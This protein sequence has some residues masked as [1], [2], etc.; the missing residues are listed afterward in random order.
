MESVPQ[1]NARMII[2]CIITYASWTAWSTAVN[3]MLIA[4]TQRLV[5]RM[6]HVSIKGVSQQNVSLITIYINKPANQMMKHIVESIRQI[7]ET[8]LVIKQAYVYTVNVG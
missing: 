6:V 5:S 4:A 8:S 3:I 7:A 1:Q 2:I